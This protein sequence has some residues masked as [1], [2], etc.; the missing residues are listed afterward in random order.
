MHG[1]RPYYP[2]A[3]GATRRRYDPKLRAD[4]DECGHD[5]SIG[6][7]EKAASEMTERDNL[8]V[9]NVRDRYHGWLYQL[10]VSS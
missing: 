10:S 1:C 3:F 9:I 7:G 5:S 2:C 6:T 4:F 8:Y